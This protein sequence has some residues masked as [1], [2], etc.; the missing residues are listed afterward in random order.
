MFWQQAAEA[1]RHLHKSAAIVD[2]TLPLSQSIFHFGFDQQYHLSTRASIA[3]LQSCLLQSSADPA[4]RQAVLTS[5]T[6]LAQWQLWP[7]LLGLLLHSPAAGTAIHDA[8]HDSLSSCMDCIGL[9]AAALDTAAS[10]Q[11]H[12]VRMHVVDAARQLSSD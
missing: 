6:S 12:G 8:T 4:L 7:I 11:L 2:E 10:P 5:G 3:D 1:R 9:C